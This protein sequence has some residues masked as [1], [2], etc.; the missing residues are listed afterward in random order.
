MKLSPLNIRNQQFSKSLRGYDPEE[1]HAF[2]DKI[3]EELEKLNSENESQKKE[4]E[5][6]ASKLNE[7]RKIEKNLQD[8]LLKAHE[9]SSKAAE[10]AKKHGGLIVKEAEIKAA[11]I[12]ENAKGEAES[13]RNAVLALKE[14]KNLLVAKL[15]ALIN[16]QSGLLEMKIENIEKE[17]PPVKIVP[18]EI[19]KSKEEN[20]L[21]INIDGIIDKLL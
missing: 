9:S 18:E 10:S 14:E 1:V 21:D 2:L 4:L 6:A 5:K 17:K 3:A 13:L 20:K 11:Q 19:K 7:Y 8:T 12:I 15:K 16:T